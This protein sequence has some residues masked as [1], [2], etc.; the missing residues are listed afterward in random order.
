M[1][2]TALPC[3]VPFATLTAETVTN[4]AGGRAA[5]AAYRPA[6]VIVPAA[7]SPPG[8]PFTAQVTL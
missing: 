5:G 2:T 4:P 3:E 6:L 8:M 7:G 1:L